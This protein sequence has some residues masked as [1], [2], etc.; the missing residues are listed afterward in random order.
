MWHNVN[1]LELLLVLSKAVVKVK[2]K[3]MYGNCKKFLNP[4]NHFHNAYNNKIVLRRSLLFNKVYKYSS[5]RANKQV[6]TNI[7]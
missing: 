1:E 6:N 7:L 4:I 5:K 3:H 2:N